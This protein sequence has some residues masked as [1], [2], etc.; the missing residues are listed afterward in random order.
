MRYALVHYHELTLKKGNRAYFLQRLVRN[1]QRGLKGT[2]AGTVERPEGRLLVGLPDGVDERE[3]A[4]RISR[5]FGVAN[6]AMAR[7]VPLE[8]ERL[9]EAVTDVVKPLRPASFRITAKRGNKRFPLTSN[10]INVQLGSLVNS[11]TGARVDLER[12][13]LTIYVEVLD[14]GFLLSLDRMAGPGG[15]PAG[16]SGRVACLL[17]GGLDSPVAAYRM[18]KRGAHVVFVHFHSHPFVSRASQDK[19][20]E[21]VELLTRYQAA[22]RLFLVPFGEVQRE[23]VLAVPPPL[24]VIVYRRLMIRIAE[25]VAKSVRAEALVTGEALGQVASQTLSN[26]A[27]IDGA[28]SLP[29]L[30]PLVGMDKEEIVH[31][32]QAIGTYEIS[33]QP[34]EDCCSLFTPKHP[35]TKSTEGQLAAA[36]SR[37]DI[38]ALVD[39]A[40]RR[41]DEARFS[42]P[43]VGRGSPME[44]PV[45]K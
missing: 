23:V 8:M 6:F 18:M 4:A 1:L 9:A 42:Y 43:Q 45:G 24:R 41:T 29:I 12:P 17:S 13:Q 31:Q 35:A 15:L 28:A 33:I 36:E 3:V 40:R 38:P 26:M 30:R 44:H 7:W 14:K 20:R 10:Q 19:A 27:V 39:A 37:L 25:A 34:D 32:A 21:L 5:T 11:L 2:G 22:S 16:I